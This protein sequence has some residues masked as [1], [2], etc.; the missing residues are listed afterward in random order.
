LD[1]F[2]A[3]AQFYFEVA[4]IQIDD[5]CISSRALAPAGYISVPSQ[6]PISTSYPPYTYWIRKFTNLDQT[7]Y[8]ITQCGAR[9]EEARCIFYN[10]PRWDHLPIT[11]GPG[12][13]EAF[14]PFSSPEW[15]APDCVEYLYLSAPSAP[16][17][18]ALVFNEGWYV[19]NGGPCP[20]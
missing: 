19:N 14:P 7:T 3:N 10:D 20:D 4:E 11:L 12:Q 8:V 15:G 1:L 6:A 17:L 13:S 5:R 9:V 16:H 2:I 18:R